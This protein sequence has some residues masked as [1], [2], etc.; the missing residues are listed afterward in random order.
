MKNSACF[1]LDVQEQKKR[2][3]VSYAPIIYSNT[4]Y[5]KVIERKVEIV[6]RL[7]NIYSKQG[8]SL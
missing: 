6:D 8:D 2:L 4:A 5:E 3:F 7:R 1:M